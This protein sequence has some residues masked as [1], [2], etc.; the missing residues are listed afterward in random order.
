MVDNSSRTVAHQLPSHGPEA[1]KEASLRE[2][3]RADHLA[4]RRVLR[5]AKF[6]ARTIVVVRP[7]GDE[8]CHSSSRHF[9][10]YRLPCP[11]GRTGGVTQGSFANR[12]FERL[13][14]AR[15]G[16]AHDEIPDHRCDRRRRI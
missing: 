13:K 10:G 2:A 11:V 7:Y 16:E 6:G 5:G 4:H 12:P 14:R 9:R 8:R 15:F 3:L 1:Q